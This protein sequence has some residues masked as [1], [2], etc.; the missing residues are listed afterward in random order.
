MISSRQQ[1]GNG[2]AAVVPSA[3]A[4]APAGFVFLASYVTALAKLAIDHYRWLL[5]LIPL[6]ALVA[7]G[8]SAWP[9]AAGLA[10]AVALYN[11]I[12]S[13][14][15]RRWSDWA[16]SRALYLR[17]VEIGLVCIGLS[18][19]YLQG[20][21]LENHFY[22]DGFY[23]IFV[24]LAGVSGGRK[25]VFYSAPVAALAVAVGQVM[26]APEIPVIFSWAGIEY[27]VSVV[28]YAGTFGLFFVAIGLLTYLASDFESQRV[29]SDYGFG[30]GNRAPSV[31]KLQDPA[32]RRQI[33]ETTAHRERLA[34]VGEVTAQ[35]VHGL[36][37]PLTGISTIIDYLLDTPGQA[38]R[39]S[40]ELIKSEVE[41]ASAYVRELLFFTRRDAIHPTVSLNEVLDRA[42]RLFA[43][44]DR[45]NRIEILK[46]LSPD[47]IYIPGNPIQIEQIVLNL[48]DNAHHAVDGRDDGLIMIRTRVEADRVALE[49][50]DNGSGIPA[51]I[52]N[53][54]FEPFF[55]T[56]EPG[57]GTGLGLAIVESIV[58]DCGGSIAVRSRPGAGTTFIISL[59]LDG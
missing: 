13:V 32:D 45:D 19:L 15:E 27:W 12:A 8:M 43:L 58:R 22:Y 57:L 11:M 41:R 2:R 25:G 39:D 1:R 4:C 16:A 50:S 36:S 54:I 37:S 44:K 28:L 29:L 21:S 5:L 24:A 18:L 42:V 34:T 56:K 26:L 17:C 35:V 59:P 20:E 31:A 53:R 49:V 14:A 46:E 10:A 23:A 7:H 55:T 47:P 3:A 48:L 51:E 40:L 33:V 9:L 6:Y 38:Q 30:N 52:Q